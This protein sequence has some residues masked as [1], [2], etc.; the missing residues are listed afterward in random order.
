MKRGIGAA[1]MIMTCAVGCTEQ[2]RHD[3]AKSAQ[4]TFRVEED[5]LGRNVVFQT[6]A[7]DHPAALFIKCENGKPARLTI[8]LDDAP[9]SPPPLA[10]VFGAFRFGHEPKAEIEMGWLPP[11]FWS[12]RQQD[13]G[14][15]KEIVTRFF[16]GND[17]SFT[18]P[19]PHGTGVALTWI[20]PRGEAQNACLTKSPNP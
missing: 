19:K 10:G 18:L 20:A 15:E 16:Q 4:A 5:R 17:L 9:P 2:P 3:E 6:A 1:A 8:Q 13:T 14:N 11:A 7:N 12:P